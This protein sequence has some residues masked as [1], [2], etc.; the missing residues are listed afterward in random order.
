MATNLYVGNLSPD[1]TSDDLRVVFGAF[2]AVL[3]AQVAVDRAGRSRGF[4]FVDMGDG[5][6]KAIKALKG[7]PLHGR[8][9]VVYEIKPLPGP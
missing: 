5:A 8:K 2:G 4:G 7:T 6:E 1:T 3:R 9:L